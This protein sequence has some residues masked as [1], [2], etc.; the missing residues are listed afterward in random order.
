MYLLVVMYD[1]DDEIMYPRFSQQM[2]YDGATCTTG[3]T[4]TTGVHHSFLM[5]HQH[6]ILPNWE[7]FL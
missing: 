4:G 1:D 7:I 5:V 3:T 6:I 2:K